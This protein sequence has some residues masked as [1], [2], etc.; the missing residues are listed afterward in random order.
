[1]KLDS[2]ESLESIHSCAFSLEWAVL[3]WS[4]SLIY[5]IRANMTIKAALKTLQHGTGLQTCQECADVAS[6]IADKTGRMHGAL[7]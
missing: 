2:V 3:L 6:L 7:L 4:A 5:T 1:M